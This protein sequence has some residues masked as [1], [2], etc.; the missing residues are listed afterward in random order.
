MVMIV[1]MI[2][3]ENRII[4]IFYLTYRDNS[5]RSRKAGMISGLSNRLEI[6][7]QEAFIAH[8]AF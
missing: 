1:E 5:L 4:D 7:F 6:L 3:D 8:E 2:N